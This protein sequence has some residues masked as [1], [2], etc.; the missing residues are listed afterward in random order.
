MKRLNGMD[1][2]LCM[3]DVDDGLVMESMELLGPVLMQTPAPKPRRGLFGLYGASAWAAAVGVVAAVGLIASV[4]LA[5]PRIS[6]MLSAFFGPDETESTE[7][8]TEGEPEIELIPIPEDAIR[9]WERPDDATAYVS[10]LEFTEGNYL[11]IP[12]VSPSGFPVRG[13]GEEAFKDHTELVRVTVPE[14]VDTINPRAFYF[15]SSL[16]TVDLPG[17]LSQIHSMAFAGCSSLTA[18]ELPD[19]LS[20]IGSYAFS[21][22]ASLREIELPDQLGYLEPYAFRKCGSL[23]SVTIPAT[24]NQSMKGFAYLLE[25]TFYDCGSL[26]TVILPDN[27][28]RIGEK[29]FA[30]C[31]SLQRMELPNQINLNDY[32]FA[33][34]TSL[35]EVVVNG[36]LYANPTSFLRCSSLRHVRGESRS[37][38][39]SRQAFSTCLALTEL[40]VTDD[41]SLWKMCAEGYEADLNV[42]VVHCTDG[43]VSYERIEKTPSLAYKSCGDGTCRVTGMGTYPTRDPVIPSVSPDGETVVEVGGFRETDM[44]RSITIPVSVTYISSFSNCSEL[45]RIVYEG[46][47]AEWNAIRFGKNWL[48]PLSHI[49]VYCTDG[50]IILEV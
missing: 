38:I 8:T 25:G 7:E 35:T 48:N 43:D 37:L 6:D 12:A 50:E 32:A 33:H 47:V 5:G 9:Y 46:T 30:G 18:L 14:G 11:V 26:E 34:C 29:C 19:G 4:I 27:L 36:S 15:C 24:V 2:L 28:D 3:N 1:I 39:H 13:I 17:T 20:R 49:T 42:A 23:T 21:L 41:M 44:V 40:T 16:V 22:C 31:S 10:G 45:T